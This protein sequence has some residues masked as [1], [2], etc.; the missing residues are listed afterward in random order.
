MATNADETNAVDDSTQVTEDDLRNLKYG[1]TEVEPSE[2]EEDESANTDETDEDS[3]ETGEEDGQTDDQATDTEAT[4]DASDEEANEED[5]ASEFVKEFPNI[6]G[7]TLEEYAKGLEQAYKNSTAE[8]QRLRQAQLTPAANED[9][10]E[11]DDQT[12]Q[13]PVSDPVSLYMKQKMDEEITTAFSDFSKNFSSQVTDQT[14]Y[15]KFT[16]TVATLSSTI[17]Q[18]EGR[19]APPK[20]LYSKAAVILGWE[21][22]NV[23]TK[24]DKLGMALKNNAA[25][26]KTSSGAK[27]PTS[28]KSKVTDAMIAAN[29]LMYPDKTD[30][31]I[32]TELEPYV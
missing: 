24:K 22:E 29:R 9:S 15:D 16:R 10:T 7:E 18:S 8:F 30:A 31:E 2:N 23:P 3:E 17:L 12:N 5:D 27:T 6:K 13:V 26:S 11:N 4:D 14:E 21:P 25:I 20:E 1:K 19:L 32:R 28:S